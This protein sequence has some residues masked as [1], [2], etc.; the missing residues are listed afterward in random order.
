MRISTHMMLRL[1]LVNEVTVH[2]LTQGLAL[3]FD[4]NL[5]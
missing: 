1:R 3:L 5:E 4:V 2:A